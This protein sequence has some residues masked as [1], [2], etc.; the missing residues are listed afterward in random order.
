MTSTG[1]YKVSIQGKDNGLAIS[2]ENLVSYQGKDVSFE[3][4]FINKDILSLRINGKNYQVY[5]S[6]EDSRPDENIFSLVLDSKKYEVIC[7]NET[8]LLIDKFSGGKKD[9]KSKNT[10]ASPMPGVILKLN[11]KENDTV[12]KGD[13]L[14]VL[15]AMKMENEI[16]S[17]KDGV[18][19]KISVTEKSS[20]EKSQMLIELE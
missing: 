14:L 11:V 5:L 8:D 16:K 6:S 2:G 4:T 15:E 13:V 17:P 1:K 3:H 19:K 20:V 7:K 9:S 10:I 18:I 12:K